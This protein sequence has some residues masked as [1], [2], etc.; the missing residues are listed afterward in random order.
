MSLNKW[1]ERERM[2]PTFH[3]FF[4]DFW[5][6]D[7]VSGIQTGTSIPAV[8]IIEN[9][10]AFDVRLAAPGLKKEDFKI[11][12]ENGLLT[13][14]SKVKEEKES[15][16]QKITRKEFGFSSFQRSFTLPDSVQTDKIDA[17]YNQGILSIKLPKKEGN[18]LHPPKQIEIK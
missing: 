5:S 14:S 18:E 12:L 9:S 3:S 15:A 17:S 13:I 2:F 4:D 1:N 7:F 10:K 6:R 11:D 8:N 16:D